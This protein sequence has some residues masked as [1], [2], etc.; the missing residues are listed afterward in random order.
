MKEMWNERYRSASFAYG[1]EPNT[2]FKESL[3][4]YKLSGNVLFPAE[5]EGRN[6]VYGAKLGVNAF[7][8]DISDEGKKKAL[9]LA[10]AEKVEIEYT[11]GDFMTMDFMDQSFEAAVLIYAHFPPNI[12]SDYHKKIARLLKPE[13]LVIL[14]G[15]SKNNLP[16]R[17]KNPAIGGP[18][19]EEM[20]FSTES[21]S[22]DFPN[23]ETLQL[24]EVE[25]ELTEGDYHN[26]TGKVIRFV[27]RKKK[28]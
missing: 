13:G 3:N 15:F 28:E 2:F 10:T 22:A 19:I 25:T 6:A 21:I 16:Y 27:G 24:E 11:I 5:G 18:N 23:F 20:L 12:I 4:A 8:F 26:G 1:K 14:E 7:A 17:A 9:H